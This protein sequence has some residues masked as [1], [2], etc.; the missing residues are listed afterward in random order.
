MCYTSAYAIYEWY[1]ST[2]LSLLV[3]SPTRLERT[4]CS[5]S[6]FFNFSEASSLVL[7]AKFEEKK[8]QSFLMSSNLNLLI[9]KKGEI[10]QKLISKQGKNIFQFYMS[11]FLIHFCTVTL[12]QS[13]SHV[14]LLVN[15]KFDR[16][17]LIFLKFVV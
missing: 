4:S 1:L 10:I 12:S 8:V 13:Y 2:A 16:N 11:N 7:V 15:P 14:C 6:S 3:S 9:F 17:Y 5:S